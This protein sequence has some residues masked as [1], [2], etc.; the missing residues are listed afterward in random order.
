MHFQDNPYHQILHQVA[1]YDYEKMYVE[2]LYEREQ[3]KYPP[4]IRI[5]KITLKDRDYNKLNEAADWFA[6]SLRNVLKTTVLGPEYPVVSRIRNE[7]L[8]HVL[9]KVGKN[10]AM[11]Q[12]KNSIKRIEKSFNAIAQYKSIRLVY[13]V[14]HI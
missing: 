5:I 6:S 10:H 4:H 1:N 12:T 3:F 8:K 11:V 13:N 14:D 7:Y 2:Q 9:V